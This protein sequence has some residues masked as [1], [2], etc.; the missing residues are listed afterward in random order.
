MM[1]RPQISIIRLLT[2]TG[3]AM[4]F[5]VPAISIGIVTY[6]LFHQLLVNRI[7]K[8]LKTLNLKV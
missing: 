6:T 5:T 3:V 8:Y 2:F 1:P 4:S 7:A